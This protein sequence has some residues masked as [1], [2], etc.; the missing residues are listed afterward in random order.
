[1]HRLDLEVGLDAGALLLDVGGRAHAVEDD[2]GAGARKGACI[3]EPD[4][5]GRSGHNRRLACQRTHV[6]FTPVCLAG[7]CLAGLCLAGAY[8]GWFPCRPRSGRKSPWFPP[9]A[10]VLAT[11][12]DASTN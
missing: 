9:T 3:S 11:L 5:A 8:L 10:A 7:L 4:A 1:M 2:I 6:L 12:C